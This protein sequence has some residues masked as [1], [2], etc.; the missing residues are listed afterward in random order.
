MTDA[1]PLEWQ[2][3]GF[4]THDGQRLAV[5][6]TLPV[7]GQS[8]PGQVLLHPYSSEVDSTLIFDL[9]NQPYRVLK[10][11]FGLADEA[12]PF[13]NGVDFTVSVSTDG[14]GSFA[15][16]IQTAVTTNTWHSEL[17]DLPDSQDLVLKLNASAQ[18]DI[19][20]D[21]LQVKLDLLPFDSGKD[22][23]ETT[24]DNEVTK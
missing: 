3:D 9:P 22:R 14:G 1:L 18:L 7:G 8:L 13:S 5:R 12:A 23:S 6:S 2:G 20:Y 4:F 10:T 19:T 11:S 17:V 16:L 21:W 24:V 15:D